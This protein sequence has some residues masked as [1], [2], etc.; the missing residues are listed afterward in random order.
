[1]NKDQLISYIAEAMGDVQFKRTSTSLLFKMVKYPDIPQK[2]EEIASAVLRYGAGF[3][4]LAIIASTDP[5]E[6]YGVTT[7]VW[8]LDQIWIEQP[9]VISDQQ[10]KMLK[11]MDSVRTIKWDR[12]NKE[13]VRDKV[14]KFVDKVDF[15]IILSIVNNYRINLEE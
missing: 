11:D 15:N 12:F 1:M 9:V 6:T 7:V 2:A 3:E 4:R 13:T 14:K 5:Y 8:N 10:V